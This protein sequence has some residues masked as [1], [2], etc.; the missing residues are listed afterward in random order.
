ML[1]DR[2]VVLDLSF[3]FSSLARCPVADNAIS[4]PKL[5]KN[6]SVKMRLFRLRILRNYHNAQDF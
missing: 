4:D 1:C 2:V 6:K 3:H 5:P